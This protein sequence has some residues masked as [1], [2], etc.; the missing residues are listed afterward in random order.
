[1]IR[2]FPSISKCSRAL[3]KQKDMSFCRSLPVLPNV[4]LCCTFSCQSGGYNRFSFVWHP[5][6]HITLLWTITWMIKRKRKHKRHILLSLFWDVLSFFWVMLR[7]CQRLLG[8]FTNES[9]QMMF[10][11]CQPE[12]WCHWQCGIVWTIL[13]QRLCDHGGTPLKRSQ[14]IE[15]QPLVKTQK[16]YIFKVSECQH[17]QRV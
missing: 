5:H 4:S 17:N 3:G 8:L 10:F 11:P 7:R 15:S 2:L 9:K 14:S 1:M 6:H 16:N 13:K 12:Q